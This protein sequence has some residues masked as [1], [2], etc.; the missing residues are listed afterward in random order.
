MTTLSPDAVPA[1]LD[2]CAEL[3][4]CAKK[5]GADEAEAI[6]LKSQS[7][8]VRARGDDTEHV[9]EAQSERIVVRLAKGQ[10]V[11]AYYSTETRRSALPALV[12]HALSFAE[13]VEP[14]ANFA[15]LQPPSETAPDPAPSLYDEGT[16]HF[17]VA[18][19]IPW[20]LEMERAARAAD[21]RIQRSDA[22]SIDRDIQLR[23]TVTSTGFSGGWVDARLSA[24]CR[25]VVDDGDGKKRAGSAWDTARRPDALQT[26]EA[27][28]R[29][30]AEDALS[31]LGAKKIAS[32]SHPILFHP[33]AGRALLSLLGSCVDGYAVYQKRSFLADALEQSIASPAVTII[34]DPGIAG[35]LGSRPYDAEGTP[36]QATPV[37]SE[38]TLQN[39]LL[40][41]YAGRKLG[42]PSTGHAARGASGG[43][44][45]GVSNFS[46]RP[47]ADDLAGLMK[48]MQ[49]GLFVKRMMGFGFNPVTGDF[50]RGAEGFWVEDGAIAH[51]VSEVTISANF[52]ALWSGISA[53]GREVDARSRYRLPPFLVSAMTVSGA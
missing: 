37:V 51:P 19:A 49:R 13:L 35:G 17:G 8:E 23:A 39:F 42:R 15:L 16:A 33:D 44:S 24:A 4:E 26:A 6:F 27:L 21:P 47:G 9:Q 36:C 2:L 38:G 22:S 34:D 29:K 45:V 3:V 25:P 11:G 32:A 53:V 20:T 46:M 30:A 5:Q 18:D 43:I 7:L 12:T 31:M 40:D 48:K 50:S 10:R 41:G 14:D 1:A 28:G 52:R